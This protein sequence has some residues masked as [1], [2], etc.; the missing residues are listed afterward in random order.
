MVLLVLSLAGCPTRPRAPGAPV[1]R[2]EVA[3][4]AAPHEGRPYDIVP[5]ESLLTIL[6]FRAGPLAKAGHNHVIASH[7][8]RGAVYIP[9]EVLR[10][11]FELHVPVA[12]F[13]VDEPALRANE[14]R[15]DDFPPD[16]P[17]QAKEGTRRNMLSEA[18]LDAAHYPE[19]VLR[20]EPLE[21]SRGGSAN[22]VLAHVQVT[23]RDQQHSIAVPVHYELQGDEV[24]VSGE[25]PLKQTDLGLAP[26]SALLGALQVQDEMQVKFRIVARAAQTRSGS[27][28]SNS[29]PGSGSGPE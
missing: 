21:R 7:D 9:A 18:L 16:V 23:I 17:D 25:S 26:F 14:N 1:P 12:G 22:Q 15:P 8:L 20:S 11:T 6:V 19:I 2:P 4:P 10:T 13:T 24:I 29:I 5:A 28:V 27:S 3:R